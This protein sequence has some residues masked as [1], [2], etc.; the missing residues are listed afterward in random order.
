[1]SAI[2]SPEMYFG[3]DKNR[4]AIVVSQ[5]FDA[6]ERSYTA[7]EQL[8]LNH[9]ALSGA[10]KLGKDAA[11]SSADGDRIALRFRAPKSGL[12]AYTFAFGEFEA[13]AEVS[14]EYLGEIAGD[15]RR[16]LGRPEPHRHRSYSTTPPHHANLG[17]SGAY[18]NNLVEVRAV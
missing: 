4:D 6:G 1:M 14:E 10:W 5:S 18:F 7:P 8:P 17:Q 12:S 16:T 9:F 11:I 15:R 2:D 13:H 3:V